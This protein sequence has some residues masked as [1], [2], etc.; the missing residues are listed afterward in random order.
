MERVTQREWMWAVGMSVLIVAA[1]TLP[2]LAGYLAQMADWRF[3]GALLDRVDYHGYL[4]R[5]QQG[6]RGEWRFRLLFTPE[7]HEGVYSQPLYIIPGH[8]ARLG[9][10]GLPLTYQLARLVFAFLMLL[11]IYPT[12]RT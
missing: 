3:G 9:G 5:M 8:L 1:S 6:Y 2:Y 11:T 7:M 12:F 10:L 4:A